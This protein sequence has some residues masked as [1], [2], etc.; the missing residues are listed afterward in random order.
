MELSLD[1]GHRYTYADYL[2]WLD[3]IR[4]ELIDGFVRVM[5]SPRGLHQEVNMN[6]GVSLRNLIRRAGGGCKVYENLD[7]RL[8]LN[9]EEAGKTAT[10]VCPDVIVVCD[11]SKLPDDRCCV[12]A[13]DLVVEIQS[14]PTSRYDMTV[15]YSLYERG[16]VRE[17]WVVFP[18]EGV[19]VFTLGSDGK[20]GDGVIYDS[21][22]I[23]VSIF[24]GLSIDLRKLFREQSW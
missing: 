21:G 2:G 6:I 10:V 17:Y 8:P 3:G 19:H 15:K 9:G 16:G 18:L 20:Y 4:R 24:S 22:R 12:G 13:P 23:P 11:P 7:V 5:A 1:L 14:V